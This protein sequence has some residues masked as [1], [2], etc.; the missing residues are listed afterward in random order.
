MFSNW[1]IYFSSHVCLPEIFQSENGSLEGCQF[2]LWAR[3]GVFPLQFLPMVSQTFLPPFHLQVFFWLLFWG[4]KSSYDNY[5]LQPTSGPNQHNQS[6][7]RVECSAS[8]KRV[9]TLPSGLRG[10]WNCLVL[11][12]CILLFK[13]ELRSRLSL[14]LNIQ[15]QGEIIYLRN[16]VIFMSIQDQSLPCYPP[17]L[18]WRGML[19][20]ESTV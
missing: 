3:A 14:N 17:P 13:W 4:I 8:C 1:I 10:I 15:A 6:G 2:S 18:Q 20:N 12:L 16:S 19:Y 9:Q 7:P 5:C 11:I